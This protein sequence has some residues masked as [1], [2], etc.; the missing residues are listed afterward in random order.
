MA[1][2]GLWWLASVAAVHLWCVVVASPQVSIDTGCM[3][4]TGSW[5]IKENW[6]AKK[7]VLCSPIGSR[8]K[9]R[10]PCRSFYEGDNALEEIFNTLSFDAGCADGGEDLAALPQAPSTPCKPHAPAGLGLKK[11][12]N[13]KAQQALAD[14]KKSG[15]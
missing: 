10:F 15:F 8:P 5:F 12:L 11:V 3:K 14:M 9:L 4:I 13:K 7:A 2:R 6:S 1:C